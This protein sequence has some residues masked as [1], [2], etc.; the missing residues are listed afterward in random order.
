M[1]FACSHSSLVECYDYDEDA[2]S[3]D[4]I[5]SF[6]TTFAQFIDGRNR[7]VF[8]NPRKKRYEGLIYDLL[9]SYHSFLS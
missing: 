3:D 5:G 4:F 7:F 1:G 2:G 6:T 8:I 9:P